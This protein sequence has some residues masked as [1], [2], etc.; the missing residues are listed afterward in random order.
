MVQANLAQMN[1]R[2][3]GLVLEVLAV[4]LAGCS[5]APATR[6]GVRLSLRRRLWA[7]EWVLLNHA[8]VG[9]V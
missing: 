1:L 2:L 4:P 5:W 3:L 6:Q 7:W 8:R 9:V